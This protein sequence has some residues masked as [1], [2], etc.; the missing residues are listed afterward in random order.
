MAVMTDPEDCFRERHFREWLAINM[1]RG[2]FKGEE[3]WRIRV[4]DN[5]LDVTKNHTT[6]AAPCAP[7]GTSCDDMLDR[8][9]EARNEI[10]RRKD[11]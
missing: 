3:A 8:S 6:R 10:Q 2:P 7:Q 5:A 9:T 4:L 1:T 11:Y